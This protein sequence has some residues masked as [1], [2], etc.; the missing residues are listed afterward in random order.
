MCKVRAKE[1][2]FS[3]LFCWIFVGFLYIN[4]RRLS[5]VILIFFFIIIKQK[6]RVSSRSQL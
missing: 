3:L 6:V 5:G 1:Y 2:G 4:E